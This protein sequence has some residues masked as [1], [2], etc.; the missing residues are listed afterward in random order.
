V[1]GSVSRAIRVSMS[2]YPAGQRSIIRREVRVR[3]RMLRPD[4]LWALGR[5]LADRRRRTEARKRSS[6]LSASGILIKE[7]VMGCDRSP[8]RRRGVD[9][10][11]AAPVLNDSVAR[12]RPLTVD[13]AVAHHAGEDAEIVRWLSDGPSSIDAVVTYLRRCEAE[14]AAGGMLRAFGVR[15]VTTGVLV[16]TVDVRLDEPYLASGQANLAYGIH[17]GWRRRGFAVRAVALASRYVREAGLARELVIRT[18]PDNGV[19]AS[20]ALR[21]GFCYSHTTNDREGRLDWYA[22]AVD[23][24]DCGKRRTQSGGRCPDSTET[25]QGPGTGQEP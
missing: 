5:C 16:G 9:L 19:S 24:A 7:C 14:W 3:S 18:H 1:L 8:E 13:D 15:D 10:M 25:A 11:W 12:I 21:S 23:T 20:V 4:D 6:R 22:K 2:V 17:P